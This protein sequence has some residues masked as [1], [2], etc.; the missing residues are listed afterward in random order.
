MKAMSLLGFPPSRRGRGLHGLGLVLL[1]AAVCVAISA[2]AFI[3]QYDISS[4][5]TSVIEAS[6]LQI[7]HLRYLIAAVLA[8]ASTVALSAAQL[9]CATAQRTV[10][11]PHGASHHEPPEA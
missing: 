7:S 11:A 4:Y 6:L 2:K 9:L 1:L 8:V 5:R 3:S 10:S